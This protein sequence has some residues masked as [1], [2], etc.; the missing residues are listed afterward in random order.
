MQIGARIAAYEVIAKLGEGGMGEV[1]RA[2]DSRLQRDV[3]IKVLP[4]NVAADAERLARFTRE[5][6]LLASLNH[7][8]IAHVYGVE[9][10]ATTRALVM[11]LVEGPT[12]ADQIAGGAIPLEEAL[13]IARQIAE[14]LD[15]AHERG[16]IHRDLKPANI[17]LTA[18]GTVKVLDFGLAKALGPGEPIGA[19][20]SS[21]TEPTN[22]PTLTTPAVTQAGIILGTAAYMS[23]EQARGKAVDK[24]ADIWA[25]G[26]VL[27]EMLT[28][29][30][31]FAGETMSDTIAE[32]LK[33]DF[34]WSALPA[35]TPPG[36][37][38]LLE[39][40][41]QRDPRKR[42]R[43]IGDAIAELDVSP[44]AEKAVTIQRKAGVS[45]AIVVLIVLVVAA[46]AAV[47]AWLLKPD[48][49]PALRSVVRFSVAIDESLRSLERQAIAVSPDGST[50][51]IAAGTGILLRRLDDDGVTPLPNTENAG[52]M[53]FSPDGKSLAFSSPGQLR[54]LDLGASAAQTLWSSG[55]SSAILLGGLAWSSDG[56]LAFPSEGARQAI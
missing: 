31:L 43:D 53:A 42:L 15:A 6:Q 40:A 51:A 22:S 38:R 37:R 8:H 33:R 39:R 25:F 44:A 56:T 54:K 49:P 48:P 30:Q 34:D 46:S 24:R 20:R 7:P 32:V 4:A 23:P 52:A 19:V 50:L 2:R 55:L 16:I 1:Y 45:V 27:Y 14:A 36:V 28:G 35:A 10:D 3:A 9:Q 11:E 47:A 41:L 18:D 26:V 29:R 13:P 5:A 12:L 21:A 17:K